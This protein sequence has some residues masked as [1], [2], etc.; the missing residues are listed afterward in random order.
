MTSTADFLQPCSVD[1]L[2][3]FSEARASRATP[4]AGCCWDVIT[5]TPRRRSLMRRHWGFRAPPPMLTS[6]LGGFAPN[7]VKVC[8]PCASMS[9]SPSNKPWRNKASLTGRGSRMGIKDGS[10][11]GNLSPGRGNGRNA[12]PLL[13]SGLICRLSSVSSSSLK[14]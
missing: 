14:N 4:A 3:S 2:D 5:G 8:H 13:V 11:T 1:G 12:R 9:A 6:R 10:S 7:A